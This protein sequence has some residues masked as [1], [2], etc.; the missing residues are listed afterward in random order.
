[1]RVHARGHRSTPAEERMSCLQRDGVFSVL[2]KLY[3]DNFS[4]HKEQN[5][6]II[7]LY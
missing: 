2:G 5:K 7:V 3:W 1:M 4:S 6:W